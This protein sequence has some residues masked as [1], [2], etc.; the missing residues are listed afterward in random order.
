MAARHTILVVDD[1]PDVVK[2]VKDLL[3]LD[4]RVLGATSASEGLRLLQSE[5]VHIVMTDQ[6]MPEMTGVEFLSQVRGDTPEAIRLLFTGYADIKAVI[7]AIN[8]GNV[9]RYISKPWDPDE[10]QSIIREAGQRYDLLRERKNLLIM[11]REQNKELERTN[12]EL[13]RANELKHAFIQ[14]ASHELRTPLTILIGLTRLS[15]TLPD[16][17]D[18]LKDWLGR[19]DGAAKRLQHLVDQL[20]TILMAGKFELSAIERKTT[21]LAPLLNQAADDVRPFTQLRGQRLVV[22]L[23]DDLG[24]MR[25][26]A[27][28]LRDGVNHLLLNA[29][30]FTPD[31]GTVTLSAART[32]DR[33]AEIHISDTGCGIDTECQARLFEPFFTGFDVS[34]H[35]SGTFEHG[36]KGLGLGLS[37]VKAFVEMHGGHIDVQSAEGRGTT[38]TIKLP[39]GGGDAGPANPGSHAGASAV[40][41][42]AR[43]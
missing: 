15:A 3:R 41:S 34:H 37:V 39:P 42:S 26:A 6:R 9:Y 18:P 11:M 4:Y 16:V 13:K 32:P 31:G 19:I 40:S 28:K 38:F 35:S 25:L 2:S 43:T 24:S 33:G 29:I 1:E 22:E 8:Q 14:V 21:E 20:I 23:P 27:E 30:K 5:E 17:K 10:L 7:D 36:R 12:A